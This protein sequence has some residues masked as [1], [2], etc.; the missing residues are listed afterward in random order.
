VIVSNIEADECKRTGK[1]TQE[2]PKTKGGKLTEDTQ[3]PIVA[4]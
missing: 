3:K 4:E 1:L 2:I